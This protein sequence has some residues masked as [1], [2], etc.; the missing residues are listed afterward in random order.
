MKQ[1]SKDSTIAD[2]IAKG[3]DICQLKYD[4]WW[5]RTDFTPRTQHTEIDYLSCN[6]RNLRQDI[7]RPLNQQIPSVIGEFMYGREWAKHPDREGNIYVHDVYGFEAYTYIERYR[8][9]QQLAGT[10]PPNFVIVQ[11]YPV[12][13][14]QAIWNTAIV[15]HGFEGLVFKKWSDP[16]SEPILKVKAVET[17]DMYIV[18]CHRGDG[19]YADTLGALG[20][21]KEPTGAE[22]TRCSGMTDSL[23]DEIWNDQTSFIGRCVEIKGSQRSDQGIL[24]HPRFISFR[25]D[26]DT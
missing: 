8:L 16:Q 14:A 12:T 13:D 5:C 18:A 1:P 22:V 9:L 24:Q 21:S 15:K 6:G 19:K 10:L 17:E 26:K 3:Y 7:C 4:G 11:S 23:R 20:L 2:A 25:E